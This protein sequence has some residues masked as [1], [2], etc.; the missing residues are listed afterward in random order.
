MS[1]AKYDLRI[2]QGAT[3]QL[4]LVWKDSD[5][6]PLDLSPMSA[7]M[8]IRSTHKAATPIVS[9]TSSPGGGI[10]LNGA[11]GEI[12]IA[13]SAEQTAGIAQSSGVYDLELVGSDGF[14]TRLIEGRVT[15][16]PEVTR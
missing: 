11:S 9:L 2:E 15:V 13:L 14:V 4:R 16:S 3:Y 7:R 8:Q 1:A 6:Q 10:T 5:G 12:D